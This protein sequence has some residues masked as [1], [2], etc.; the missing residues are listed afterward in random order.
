MVEYSGIFGFQGSICI[1][2]GNDEEERGESGEKKI[3]SVLWGKN[4]FYK[5]WGDDFACNFLR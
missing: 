4:L 2:F 1:S 3:W 5:E